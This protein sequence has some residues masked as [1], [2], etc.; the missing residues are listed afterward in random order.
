LTAGRSARG[1]TL[2]E[3]LIVLAVIGI[4]AAIAIPIY[5]NVQAKARI[6]QAQATARTLVTAVSAYS[7][8]FGIIPTAL[9]DLTALST[10]GGVTGGPFIKAIP[11]PPVGWTT[12]TYATG[13]GS[14]TIS[15]SGDGTSV[16]LP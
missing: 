1:F 9:T 10:V 13:G 15:A 12:Y 6:A 3:L 8:T 5:L 2:I 14:F 4:L 7:S 11:V 16:A